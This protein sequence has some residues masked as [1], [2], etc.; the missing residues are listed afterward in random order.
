MLDL[1]LAPRIVGAAPF[2]YRRRHRGRDQTLLRQDADQRVD[3]RLGHG[4]AEQRCID[5]DAGRIAFGNH[6]AVVH[7]DHRLG[8][9]ERRCR[10]LLEGMIERRLQRR[11]GWFDHVRYRQ[12]RGAAAASSPS[13]LR[14]RSSGDKALSIQAARRIRARRETPRGCGTVRASR[15]RRSWRRGR[16]GSGARGAGGE[17]RRGRK[18]PRTRL[19]DRGPRRR[20]S[21][22]RY[23]RRKPVATRTARSGRK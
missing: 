9:A 6:L 1:D 23:G 21:S 5:A 7:H 15:R 2:R 17:S 20:S 10:R 16:S 19:A 8:P 12:S 14:H 11:I 18:P 22:R 3:H 13:A 4:E